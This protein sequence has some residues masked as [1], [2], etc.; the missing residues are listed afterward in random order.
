MSLYIHIP[1]KLSYAKISQYLLLNVEKSGHNPAKHEPLKHV[2]DSLA[3]IHE[4]DVQHNLKHVY[5]KVN[6]TKAPG[7]D[8]IL[9]K[10]EDCILKVFSSGCLR[11]NISGGASY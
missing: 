6:S 9:R 7:L 1:E 5:S 2:V 4:M 3:E 10:Y 8:L 11:H